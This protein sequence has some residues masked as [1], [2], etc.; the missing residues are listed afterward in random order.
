MGATPEFG[1]GEALSQA[2]IGYGL[3]ITVALLTACVIWGV[4]T[5]LESM[6]KKR[7][8]AAVP[9]PAAVSVSVEPQP[10]PEDDTARHVAAIAAAVYTAIGAHRLVYIGEARPG[11]AWASTGRVLHQTSHLP[12]RSPQS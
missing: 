1:V 8:A 12:K 10:E 3:T 11:A 4:V 2:L 7:K 6:Q 5:T 9:A